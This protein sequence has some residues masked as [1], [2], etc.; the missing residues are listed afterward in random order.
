MCSS[1]PTCSRELRTLCPTWSCALCALCLTYSRAQHASCSTYSSYLR[2]SCP[3]HFHALCASC[4]TCFR[5]LPV[6]Y[7]TCR[8]ALHTSVLGTLALYML[9]VVR[10]FVPRVLRTSHN[11]LPHVFVPYMFSYLTCFVLHVPTAISDLV[12]RA[13]WDLFPYVPYCLVPCVL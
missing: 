8:G 10:A 9:S 3:T 7:P 5:G 12:F 13:L 6:S 2:V 4:P 1:C 11:L